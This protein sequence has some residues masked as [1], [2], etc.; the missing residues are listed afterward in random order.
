[1]KA[2]PPYEVVTSGYPPEG[3]MG[4]PNRHPGTEEPWT[5]TTLMQGFVLLVV[6]GALCLLI[7]GGL[8]LV[9][10]GK[11][12]ANRWFEVVGGIVTYLVGAVCGYLFRSG[13][14]HRPLRDRARNEGAWPTSVQYEEEWPA[15][16]PIT[17]S[18]ETPRNRRGRG[19][20]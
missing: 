11:T 1:M 2:R 14:S 3:S 7:L 15:P 18:T 4:P 6:A 5:P 20:R 9:M 10:V 8:V 19:H 17:V 13:T 12:D 16:A